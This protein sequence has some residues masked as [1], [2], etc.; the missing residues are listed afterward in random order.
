MNRSLSGCSPLV[1]SDFRTLPLQLSSVAYPTFVRSLSD[2]CEMPIRLRRDTC[3]VSI[4][5]LA[6]HICVSQLDESAKVND[7]NTR[8]F[9]LVEYKRVVLQGDVLTIRID[10]NLQRG[11]CC[12]GLDVQWLIVGLVKSYGNILVG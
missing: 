10:L 5:F 12:L 8:E 11:L 9:L 7:F 2:F 3:L 1:M 4:G 6:G